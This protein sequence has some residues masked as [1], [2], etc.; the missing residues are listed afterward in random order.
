MISAVAGLDDPLERIF[1]EQLELLGCEPHVGCGR[2][3]EIDMK[4][5]SLEHEAAPSNRDH[6]A[7]TTRSRMAGD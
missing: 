4:T 7:E 3:R 1:R 5:I 2:Q 6:A